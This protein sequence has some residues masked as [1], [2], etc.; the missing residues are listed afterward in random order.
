MTCSDRKVFIST[1]ITGLKRRLLIYDVFEQTMKKITVPFKLHR[2]EFYR[3]KLYAEDGSMLYICTPSLEVIRF[4][5]LTKIFA[6]LKSSKIL[7]YTA[8]KIRN[9]HLLLLEHVHL[10]VIHMHDLS[11]IAGNTTD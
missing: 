11:K 6:T 1:T 10:H 9:E 4:I 8:L 7:F 2:I 3:N 5:P